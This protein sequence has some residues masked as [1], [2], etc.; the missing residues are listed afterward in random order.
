MPTTR[1]T[2]TL[3]DVRAGHDRVLE[4]AVRRLVPRATAQPPRPATA[5]AQRAPALD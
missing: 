1:V 3:A 4:E 2:P 5:V